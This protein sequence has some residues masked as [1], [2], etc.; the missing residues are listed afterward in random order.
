[1]YI[2]YSA[3]WEFWALQQEYEFEFVQLENFA[4]RA[5]LVLTF[6]VFYC[7]VDIS[8]GLAL[9]WKKASEFIDLIAEIWKDIIPFLVFITIYLFALGLVIYMFGQ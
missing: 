4:R 9:V 6:N 5:R 1:M 2:V 7:V 3:A 8:Y